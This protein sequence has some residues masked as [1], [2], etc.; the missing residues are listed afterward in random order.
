MGVIGGTLAPRDSGLSGGWFACCRA[1]WS[2]GLSS[3]STALGGCARRGTVGGLAGGVLEAVSRHSRRTHG[4]ARLIS[5]SSEPCIRSCTVDAN[6]S[7]LRS[8]DGGSHALLSDAGIFRLESCGVR[9][10]NRKG[11]CGRHVLGMGEARS[12]SGI[13]RTTAAV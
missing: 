11:W 2:N 7:D 9:T 5:R 12:A 8:Q 1:R 6:Q 4:Y 13:P 3:A 10:G